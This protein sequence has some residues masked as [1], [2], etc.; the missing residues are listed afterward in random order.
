[1]LAVAGV[2]F[3]E[4]FGIAQPWWE[5]GNKVTSACCLMSQSGMDPEHLLT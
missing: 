3:T 1:M 2:L 4:L 5:L